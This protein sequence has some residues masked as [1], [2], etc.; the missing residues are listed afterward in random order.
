MELRARSA[1]MRMT[2]LGTRVRRSAAALAVAPGPARGGWSNS[3][4]RRRR[5]RPAATAA[6]PL[7]ATATA[8]GRS[9]Q[10]A[11]AASWARGSGCS[12]T[13]AQPRV[14]R[15][16]GPVARR[17]EDSLTRASGSNG[18]SWTMHAGGAAAR[19]LTIHLADGCRSRCKRKR[20]RGERT[21]SSPALRHCLTPRTR[22]RHR[23]LN[24]R[25][26]LPVHQ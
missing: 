14:R 17:D 10:R 4:S 23:R 8:T 12:T 16:L 20:Y 6:S 21:P 22:T 2:R 7:F 19:R 25:R 11:R 26:R 24:F 5:S 18:D 15:P 1:R 9:T 13:H 3:P